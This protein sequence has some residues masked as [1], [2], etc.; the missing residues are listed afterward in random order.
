M[1]RAGR[2]DPPSPISAKS[3]A[4]GDEPRSAEEPSEPADGEAGVEFT[5]WVQTKSGKSVYDLFRTARTAAAPA[6]L[7]VTG[8]AASLRPAVGAPQATAHP[9]EVASALSSIADLA[10]RLGPAAAAY[11]TIDRFEVIGRQMRSGQLSSWEAQQLQEPLWQG[12]RA[13]VYEPV[14]RHKD[15]TTSFQRAALLLVGAGS[16]PAVQRTRLRLHRYLH[17]A[18]DS[19]LRA[20]ATELG[21][22][23]VAARLDAFLR[24][25]DLNDQAK[26]ALR[27]CT[28]LAFTLTP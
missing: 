6:P 22:P 11:Q 9:G 3:P 17:S 23:E 24:T 20:I 26:A 12:I 4:S 18:V 25:T 10:E 1:D 27:E 15:P 13:F 14:A 8:G 19:A 7:A 5:N 28:D 16:H 2:S 21:P